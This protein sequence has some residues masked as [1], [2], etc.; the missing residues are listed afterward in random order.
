MS[1][2]SRVKRRE[3]LKSR[4]LPSVHRPFCV[5]NQRIHQLGEQS[6]SCWIMPVRSFHIHD[7]L[8]ADDENQHL[9]LA[10]NTKVPD[11]SFN[12]IQRED[13]LFIH[14]C[15]F[16]RARKSLPQSSESIL[17]LSKFSFEKN[18]LRNPVVP[19][20]SSSDLHPKRAE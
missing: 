14:F 12:R 13:S 18:H 8:A 11:S 6:L 16:N 5:L 10:E 3:Y 15:V 4:Q 7:L 1:N 17:H 9:K 2:K 20:S 19:L